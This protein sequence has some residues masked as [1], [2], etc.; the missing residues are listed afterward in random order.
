M[1]PGGKF[2]WMATAS[3]CIL[4]GAGLPVSRADEISRS[5]ADQQDNAASAAN[6]SGDYVLQPLDLIHVEV[7]QEPDLERSVRLTRESTV[8]LP[9]VGNVNLKDKTVNQ[10]AAFIRQL[11]DQDYLVNPQI[12]VTVL[13]YN[14]RKV[15]VLGSVNNPGTITFRPE[16][17]MGLIEAITRA[18]GFSRLA[19]RSKVKLTRTLPDGT[20]QTFIIDVDD[21]IQ[22]KS[23]DPWYLQKEDIIYVPERIL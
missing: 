7:F 2:R 12:T 11:Y 4:M 18:G 16:Q 3:L 8:N 13:D 14:Q 20:S 5:N 17:K 19:D 10:A 21:L 6:L 15:D 23:T 22:G 1:H 9:L